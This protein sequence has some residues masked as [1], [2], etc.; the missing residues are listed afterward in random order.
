MV[1]DLSAVG[2]KSKS[3]GISSGFSRYGYLKTGSDNLDIELSEM[4]LIKTSTGKVGAEGS[5]VIGAQEVADGELSTSWDNGSSMVLRIAQFKNPYKLVNH[6][7]Q[8]YNDQLRRYLRN[9]KGDKSRIIFTVARAYDSKETKSQTTA[10]NIDGSISSGDGAQVATYLDVEK[11]EEKYVKDGTI[12]A[13][14][15]A[16]IIW[17]ESGD[18]VKDISIEQ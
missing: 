8:P 4:Q 5:G 16:K 1:G 10:G 6:L 15:Y 9:N 17:E 18:K 13:F 7:N 11:Q 2:T 12:V 3:G 14:Q